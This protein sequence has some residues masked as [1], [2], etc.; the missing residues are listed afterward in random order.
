[1]VGAADCGPVVNPN[2]ARA[3]IEGGVHLGLSAALGERLTVKDGA[4]EQGNFD[5]Y[6]VL[7]ITEAPRSIEVHFAETDAHPTGLGETGVPPAA[8]ALVNAIYA[9]T[10]VR[11]RSLPIG[12]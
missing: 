5:G 6:P 10:G 4:I 12:P 1:V 7:R 9:A 3:Q 8:P 2:G 11:H